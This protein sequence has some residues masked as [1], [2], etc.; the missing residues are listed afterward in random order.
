MK[1]QGQRDAAFFTTYHPVNTA[2]NVKK[3]ANGSIWDWI[4]ERLH[5]CPGRCIP[6]VA[7]DFNGHLG[8]QLRDGVLIADHD[9]PSVRHHGAEAENANGAM[10]RE[11]CEAYEYMVC[12]TLF[13][14][15]CGPTYFLQGG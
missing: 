1:I 14:E 7:G 4:E 6:I 5:D 12:N 9:S 8:A 2:A 10:L 13:E 11:F 3:E 15:G